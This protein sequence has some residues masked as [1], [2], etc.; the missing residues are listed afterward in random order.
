[1]RLKRNTNTPQAIG[2]GMCGLALSPIQATGGRVVGN[3]TVV[4]DE[5]SVFERYIVMPL[6]EAYMWCE[7]YWEVGK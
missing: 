3:E 4:D 7:D 1:M 5:D 6:E 2:A